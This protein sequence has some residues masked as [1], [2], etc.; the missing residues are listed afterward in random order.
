MKH[1]LSPSVRDAIEN[2]WVSRWKD[3]LGN[4]DGTPRQ[5]MRAYVEDLDISV[6]RLDD[7]MDWSCWSNDRDGDSGYASGDSSE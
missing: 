3:R 2:D 6:A 1:D 7:E 5:I 4:P